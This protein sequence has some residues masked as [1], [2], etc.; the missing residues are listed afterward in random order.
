MSKPDLSPSGALAGIALRDLRGGGGEN[1]NAHRY[2]VPEDFKA[3]ID[4]EAEA[5]RQ[6]ASEGKV[7]RAL[8]HSN[9]SSD[10]SGEEHLSKKSSWGMQDEQRHKSTLHSWDSVSSM[11]DSGNAS[12]NARA[13]T[14]ATGGNQ[15]GIL[16]VRPSQTSSAIITASGTDKDK[17]PL[18]VCATLWERAK[19]LD[20][21]LWGALREMQSAAGRGDAGGS[22]AGM[23]V[24]IAAI[25]REIRAALE[26]IIFT[27][28]AHAVE[29]KGAD[30]R[31]WLMDHKLS[32]EAAKGLKGAYDRGV[33]QQL[34]VCE[35]DAARFYRRLL[36]RLGK[37][38]QGALAAPSAASARTG[39]APLVRSLCQWCLLCMGDLAR[40]QV[41][42]RGG[43]RSSAE[44]RR[45]YLRAL[46]L[47]PMHG[48][49]HNQLAVLASYEGNDFESV[50]RYFRAMMTAHPFPAR[51]NLLALFEK[52]RDKLATMLV[53]RRQRDNGGGSSSRGGGGHGRGGGRPTSAG[54]ERADRAAVDPS[55]SASDDSGEEQMALFKRRFLAVHGML[56]TGVG[57]E[58]L[59]RT[60]CACLQDMRLLLE[61]MQDGMEAEMGRAMDEEEGGMYRELYQPL[62]PQQSQEPQ[63]PGHPHGQGASSGGVGAGTGSHGGIRGSTLGSVEA[64]GGDAGGG[65]G[66]HEPPSLAQGASLLS[67][68]PSASTWSPRDPFALQLLALCLFTCHY[69]LRH[70]SRGAAAQGPEAA[71][72]A[73]VV[74]LCVPRGPWPPLVTASMALLMEVVGCLLRAIRVRRP[75]R[76]GGRISAGGPGTGGVY[77]GDGTGDSGQV[78]NGSGRGLVT[79]G[80]GCSVYS[81]IDITDDG[82]DV[83]V[84]PVQALAI[85]Q[86][87]EVIPGEP[88]PQHDEQ[89]GG[90][91]G[92]GAGA[93]GHGGG[94]EAG[95]GVAPVVAGASSHAPWSSR[96]THATPWLGAVGVF[97]G[98]MHRFF[99][100][101]M[102][103]DDEDSKRQLAIGLSSLLNDLQLV[104]ADGGLP[105]VDA[106]LLDAQ[107][108][109]DAELA[110]FLPMVLAW[111]RRTPQATVEAAPL[112]D[113]AH[114]EAIR[115]ARILAFGQFAATTPIPATSGIT[116]AAA[117]GEDS[118]TR[119]LYYHPEVGL[120]SASPTPPESPVDAA[121]ALMDAEDLA[122]VPLT[123]EEVSDMPY[124]GSGSQPGSMSASGGTGTGAGTGGGLLVVDP[125]VIRQAMQ[126]ARQDRRRA[127]GTP[128]GGAGGRP[129]G[130][131]PSGRGPSPHAVVLDA[132]DRN[133]YNRNL[134]YTM[135]E[136]STGG[137]GGG[138]SRAFSSSGG[139]GRLPATHQ[140]GMHAPHNE[141]AGTGGQGDGEG[142]AGSVAVPAMPPRMVSSLG[143]GAG[144]G[145]LGAVSAAPRLIIVDAP[146]VA[147]RHGLKKKFSC[148]GI[149]IA[150]EYWRSRGI[151]AL[152]FLPDYYLDYDAVGGWKSAA[153]LGMAVK[154]SRIPDSIALLQQ[155]VDE[156]VLILTPPQ[157]YDDSYCISYARAH[158]A[159]IVTNDRYWDNVDKAGGGSQ[160]RDVLAW[161]RSHCISYT[162]VRDEFLPNPDFVFPP[163]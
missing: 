162:F 38:H 30:Q 96:L 146:N 90:G 9:S 1:R 99:D 159:C 3:T 98:W 140:R 116:A 91:E 125:A 123:D 21:V 126:K 103:M 97:V 64:S 49:P 44:A 148:R 143:A 18:R 94:E 145:V 77:G 40:Y 74:E 4:A 5:I 19:K 108:P 115:I 72:D 134:P 10:M 114:V 141:F 32:R 54:R 66:H 62:E 25:A 124:E 70:G 127:A 6:P 118:E 2:H 57:L 20:P 157:D 107:L 153:R 60:A 26:G 63:Q 12:S 156:G 45:C 161:I 131:A 23:G 95:G 43:A 142:A 35:A 105:A 158:G 15:A 27:D 109:E 151:Q 28:L 7:A 111:D 22:G 34:L 135:G 78:A 42:R 163:D 104:V 150:V 58:E 56:F 101:C 119:F 92:I 71:L 88:Q 73:A 89:V 33:T 86:S 69:A 93:S 139:G 31:V 87:G 52:N 55:V 85:G 132:D 154:Q 65:R 68:D 67:S 133:D 149:Q 84:G 122:A 50:Y 53:R 113:A 152:G 81:E 160:R 144:A 24:D 47:D 48:K 117:P 11:N 112:L 17:D 147:M 59:E 137:G 80:S 128:R 155:M 16:R 138:A 51:E 29:V 130:R 129:G 79:G 46:Q 110:G 37:E 106:A 39:G 136:A 102:A 82:T 41:A 83:L 121:E 8:V 36:Q 75:R 61:T 13:S 120:Y 76:W 14:L 100:Q